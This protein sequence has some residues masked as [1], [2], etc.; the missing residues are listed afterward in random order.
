MLLL[1][2]TAVKTDVI[3]LSTGVKTCLD[4]ISLF[5]LLS[6]IVGK[7]FTFIHRT[8]MCTDV[9]M[10]RLHSFIYSS[11]ELLLTFIESNY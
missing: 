9:I 11:I 6:I 10:Q 3:A 2:G 7:L 4:V 5:L 1:L 8:S